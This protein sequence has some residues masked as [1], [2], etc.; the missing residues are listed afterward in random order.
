MPGDTHD[1]RLRQVLRMTAQAAEDP[2]PRRASWKFVELLAGKPYTVAKRW[3]VEKGLG[4]GQ[5]PLFDDP[6]VNEAWA[7]WIDMETLKHQVAARQER[8]LDRVDSVWTAY[9][10]PLL[11]KA[12][13]G[14]ATVDE[15]MKAGAAAGTNSARR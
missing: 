5:L 6:D 3:A 4:F 1:P 8:H 11:A 10:R 13:V 15:V 7:K 2:A 9:F 12:M 14:E